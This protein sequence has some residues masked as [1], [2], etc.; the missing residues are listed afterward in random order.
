[1]DKI[2]L[3][4]IRD[5]KTRTGYRSSQ[6]IYNLMARANFP[7]PVAMGN[8]SKRWVEAEIESWIQS[9]IAD[10]REAAQ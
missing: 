2:T 3:L 4:D 1:M 7:R 6:S 10:S 9:R 8:R 5:V